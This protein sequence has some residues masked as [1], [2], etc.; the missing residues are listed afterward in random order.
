[1][2]R[3]FDTGDSA[4]AASV[5]LGAIAEIDELRRVSFSRAVAFQER[6][7]MA[8]CAASYLALAGTDA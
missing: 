1:M 2:A 5:L 4:S 3:V 7:S 6:H 8:R